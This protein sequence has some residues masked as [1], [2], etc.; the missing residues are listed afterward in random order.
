MQTGDIVKYLPTSTVGKVVATKEMDGKVW[1]KLDKTGLYYVADT[2]VPADES[3][4][5]TVSY[6]EKESKTFKGTKSVDDLNKM[7]KEVDISE[8]MPSGG[9]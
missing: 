7:E 6:K 4:Y 8:M 5:K 3:E 2:L 9:G 1:V